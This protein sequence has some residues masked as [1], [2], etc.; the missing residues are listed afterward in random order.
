MEEGDLAFIGV[1]DFTNAENL[2]PGIAQEATN[3][4]FTN[5]SA[6][7]RGGFVCLPELGAAPFLS[8]WTART[9]A[10]DNEWGSV[11]YGNGVFVAVAANGASRVM[12]S[13]DGITWTARTASVANTWSEVCFGAGVFVAVSLTGTGDR[14]MTSPD[15]ITWTTR[16]SAADS[17]WR[18]VAY[19]AGKF[20]AVAST[21][22]NYAMTSTDGITWAANTGIAQNSQC[23]T[24]GNGTF[25]AAGTSGAVATSPDGVTWTAQ[26]SPESNAWQ[27]VAYGNGLFVAVSTTGTYRVMTSPD[28]VTWTSRTAAAANVWTAVAFGYNRFVAVSNTGTNNRV[29]ISYD[30]ITWSSRANAV[31]ETWS[32]VTYGGGTFVAVGITGTGTRAMTAY[33]VTVWA[34]GTYSD[35]NA[36]DSD[37]KVLVGPTSAG[38]YSFGKNSV[39]I[40][41]PTGYLVSQQSTMVQSNNLLFIFPG[42]GQTP[43]YWD[44][45]WNGAFIEVPDYAG[46]IPGF[47]SIPESNQAT[48]CQNRLWVVN[49]KDRVAASDVLDFT[50]YDEISNDFNLNTGSSDYIVTSY[51]FGDNGLVV[52]KYKSSILLQNVQGSL[53]DVTATEV[54]RQLG[55]IGI[56]AVT[57]VGPDLVYMT[58]RDIT[59]IQL[60]LQNNLQAATEPL[61]RNIKSIIGRVNW[62][63]AYRV[64]MAYWD[65]KLY[66]ALPL[67]NSATI[68]TVLVYNFITKQWW[69]EWNFDSALGMD[70]QGFVVGNY[71]GTVRLHVVTSDGRIFVTGQSNV[72]ISGTIVAEIADSL[73]TRAYRLDNNSHIPRR[74]YMDIATNRPNF[75]VTAYAEG[76][77][78]SSAIL[79]NQ[80]YLRSQ[81]WLF[82]DAAYD[83]TNANDDYN[84]AFR[85]DYASGPDS[86]QC[87]TGFQPEMQQVYRFPIIS[88]RKGRLSWYKITN[89]TGVCNIDGVGIEARAGDRNSLV[90]V[91]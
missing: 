62:P 83:M 56:N 7:T 34:S 65:N 72:D 36:P 28:G 29:M 81:S 44:G 11:A 13:P 75:S 87:G 6:A 20:V 71:N 18:S 49:G 74:M 60:N 17:N 19:G 89:T 16:V 84:R 2:P 9:T 45:N 82:N 37:W 90:Q 91:G 54:T 86:V 41:Y 25:V 77:S 53:N 66:V 47:A 85:K 8:E 24:Y 42:E 4:D 5:S 10:A 51:P 68:N 88:R 32:C 43:I 55:I 61:S 67:D 21:G 63:Q 57:A 30:G 31:D 12:T 64:S 76:A 33:G 3:K 1:D 22:P 23:I 52:F 40:A 78:E 38:F 48:Y 79:T 69:G 39:N 14:V 59:T 27:S 80:T 46:G 58:D 35:P 26:T 73:T 50:A 70:I 15:G